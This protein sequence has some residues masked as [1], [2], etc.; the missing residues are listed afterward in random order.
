MADIILVTAAPATNAKVQTRTTVMT[1]NNAIKAR[2]KAMAQKFNKH[3][4]FSETEKELLY[5]MFRQYKN[6]IDIK[7]RKNSYSTKQSEVRSCW[8]T[9]LKRFNDHPETRQRTMR[10]IQKFWLNSK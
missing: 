4:R 8:D 7:L 2:T 1:A 6:I 3:N 10:Q 9:I 5:G